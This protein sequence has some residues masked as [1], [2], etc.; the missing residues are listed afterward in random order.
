[1]RVTVTIDRLVLDGVQLTRAQRA[2]LPTAVQSELAR[3]LAGGPVSPQPN[4]RSAS[5]VTRIGADV[6]SAVAGAL[7]AARRGR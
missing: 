5:P 4:R 2:A 1:V 3:L 6:A 7:P